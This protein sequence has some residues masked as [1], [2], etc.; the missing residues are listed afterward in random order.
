MNEAL[1]SQP[2]RRIVPAAEAAW[3][4]DALALQAEATRRLAGAERMCEDAVREA[5]ARGRDQ[6]LRE[7]RQEAAV[8]LVT[9]RSDLDRRLRDLHP[10][11]VSVV[12]AAVTRLL[13]HCPGD[14]V[15]I[16]HLTRECMRQLP[17]DETL[18][19]WVA[20]VHVDELSLQLV[21]VPL[22]VKADASL[23]VNQ[24]ILVGYGNSIDISPEHQV[25]CLGEFI[26]AQLRPLVTLPHD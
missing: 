24:A 16:S 22:R 23:S 2:S 18:T 20:P 25:S 13:G 17:L 1:P 11:L 12:T 5:A 14:A 8:L 3:W 19:L 4:S 26:A 9:M 7:G 15:L 21:A 6:G 10:Q